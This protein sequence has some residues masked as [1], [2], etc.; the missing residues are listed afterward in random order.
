MSKKHYFFCGECKNVYI[1]VSDL[2]KDYIIRWIP[3]SPLDSYPTYKCECGGCLFYV[4]RIKGMTN[5]LC[6]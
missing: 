2:D 5:V 3:N 1:Q 6:A 4:P